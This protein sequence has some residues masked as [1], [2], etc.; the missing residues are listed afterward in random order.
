MSNALYASCA[1]VL[2]LCQSQKDDLEA[3]L[4]PEIGFAPRLRQICQ[5]Q[6]AD[7]E[8]S[9]EVSQ[10]E[11]DALRM[12][13]NTWG[14][15]QALMPARK[16][17]PEPQPTA[18]AL[19]SENPYTPTATLAQAVM[20]A[21]R[22]LTEL[23]VVR[24]WLHETAP[25]PPHPEATTGYWKFTKHRVLQALRTG[26][27]G[28]D[29][30]VQEMDPDAPTREGRSLAADDTSYEKALAQTLY[31]D[32]RAGRLDDA[33]ELSRRAHQPWRAASIRGSLL[34]SWRAISTEPRDE[35]AMDDGE[36][37][38]V[39]H[40]NKRRKLW[41][42]TC[43]RAALDSRL[44]DAE[45]ALYASL[46]PSTRTATVLS[47][48]CRTW[49]DK[50]WAQIRVICEDKQSAT[51][52]RL[53]GCFWEGGIAAV[54]KGLNEVS[55][56][57]QEEEEESWRTEVEQ[58]LQSLANVSVEDGLP[59]DNP[60]HLSQLHIILDRTDALLNDFASRLRTG[61]YDPQ[62]PEYP[63]MTRFFA[64]LCLYLQMIDIPVPPLAT[65]V[66]LEA[67]LQVL[68]VCNRLNP[69]CS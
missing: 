6:I 27:H 28:A 54:E 44:S 35:E 57:A 25:Q 11:M 19:L 46:A 8:D 17:E 49:E 4:D 58:V 56:E 53:G 50:L 36:D 16:T 69:Y 13:C 59:A 62:S 26:G 10:E 55:P 32:L 43:T 41:K 2:T 31:A 64:H 23:V 3:L 61:L 66:V 20:N 5:D 18:H 42:S 29:G 21:S 52:E 40:G 22:T 24:E 30:L 67:Y 63:T 15:L 7:L 37:Y 51:L 60:F 9:G 38:D 34:F 65:Q 47:S 45:R 39:W 12:E 33:V 14:L 1:E 68:E 48:A